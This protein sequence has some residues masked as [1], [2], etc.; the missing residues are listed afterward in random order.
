MSL[1]LLCNVFLSLIESQFLFPQLALSDSATISVVTK[2]VS[3]EDFYIFSHIITDR[4]L[5]IS[6][7]SALFIL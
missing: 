4:S 5:T 7:N 2:L 3:F 1:N 6:G